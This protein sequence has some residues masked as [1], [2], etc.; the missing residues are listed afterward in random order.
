LKST[1][2]PAGP[3]PAQVLLPLGLGT[4]LSLMGDATMYAVL[5][6]HTAEAGIPLSAVGLML[7]VNRAVR[8]FLNG[9][10]GAAYDRSSRRRIFIPALIIGACST[11]LYALVRGVWPLLIARMLWGLAW[12]G[13]WVGGATMVLDVTDRANRGRWS[14]IYQTWFFL[15]AGLGSF[16]GG[17][18]TD[19]LGYVA[20]MLVGAGVTGIGALAALLWLPETRGEAR[21]PTPTSQDAPHP[22]LRRNRALWVAV[23]L[24]G[25]NR[26]VTAGVVSATLGLIVQGWLGDVSWAV[27]AATV[28]GALMAGRT[29]VAMV[30]APAAGAISDRVGSR[31]GTAAGALLLGALGMVL[32]VAESMVG[33]LAGVVLIS[34]AMSGVQ[35]LSNALTGDL[36]SEAQRGR[37]IALLHTA[38]DV[39]SAIAPPLAYWLLEPLGLSAIYM[40]CA[41]LFAVGAIVALVQ[42]RSGGEASVARLP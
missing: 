39:G 1:H 19:L 37:A 40:F 32:A 24:R 35:A 14:G 10:S 11:L 28:T 9:P 17:L 2:R 16:A 8:V 7:G 31:W 13:I 30:A 33:L 4:A 26:F 36:V 18:L 5:P 20:A 29:L 6:T 3:T 34:V 21:A 41:G 38:G 22:T 25:L 23:G 15:G 27:G 42:G 12:S